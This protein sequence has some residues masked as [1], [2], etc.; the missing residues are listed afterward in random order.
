MGQL[1][2]TADEIARAMR[3]NARNRAS[4]AALA[5]GYPPNYVQLPSG[6]WVEGW[7]EGAGDYELWDSSGYVDELESEKWNRRQ[8]GTAV[9]VALLGVVAVAIFLK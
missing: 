1:P 7:D 5:A 9:L 2:V 4:S 8:G 6:K 3:A